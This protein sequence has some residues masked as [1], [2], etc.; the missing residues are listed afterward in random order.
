LLRRKTSAPTTRG[1][2]PAS[3]AGCAMQADL[4]KLVATHAGPLRQIL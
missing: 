2:T 4:V 1:D 3:G